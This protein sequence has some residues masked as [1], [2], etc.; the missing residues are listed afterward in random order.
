MH[1]FCW[2]HFRFEKTKTKPQPTWLF[3]VV[4][5]LCQSVYA[6]P[7]RMCHLQR[8]AASPCDSEEGTLKGERQSAD[9]NVLLYFLHSRLIPLLA[10]SHA[11]TQ[12][13]YNSKKWLLDQCYSVWASYPAV[14]LPIGQ[15]VT[16]KLWTDV[17]N[18]LGHRFIQS[19]LISATVCRTFPWVSL[20]FKI[21]HY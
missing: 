19:C 13:R 18:I 6:P 17:R 2:H 14:V 9:V 1:Q 11:V 4:L 8:L 5:N 7:G 3:S 12:N 16:P 15:G 10:A 21:C 20:T